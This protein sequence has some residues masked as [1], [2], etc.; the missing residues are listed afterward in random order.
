MVARSLDSMTSD[1][2][3]LLLMLSLL[4]LVSSGCGT[5]QVV[6]Q[7]SFPPPLMEPLP[8]TL[9]VVYSD[10]FANHEFYDEAVGRNES[11]W[12]VRTGDA[13]VQFWNTLLGGMF[14]RVV[15]ITDH[16]SLHAIDDSID[17][18]LVPYIDDLQ[19]T[20]PL[21]TN[22]KVYEISNFF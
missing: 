7:G 18:V 2:K 14:E 1:R 6:V 13:H 8:I 21:H 10:E 20:L 11:D 9:G 4:V 15:V 22:V 12:L 16:D 17:A 3:S 19:Y 5:R